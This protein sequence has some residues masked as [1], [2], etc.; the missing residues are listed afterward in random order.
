MRR[1]EDVRLVDVEVGG[2]SLLA[3][4]RRLLGG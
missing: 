3:W 1:E 2:G 4:L